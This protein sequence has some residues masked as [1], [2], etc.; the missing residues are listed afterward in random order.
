MKKN[1][2]L[3]IHFPFCEQKCKYC[4]FCSFSGLYDYQEIYIEQLIKEIKDWSS[5]VKNDVLIK[6]IFLG[7][8]TPSYMNDGL[9]KKVL[10]NIYQCFDCSK[11]EEVTI[12]C[13]PN[14]LTL[15][16]LDEYKQAKINRISIGVQ[17][18]DDDVLQ[19]IG[20]VHKAIDVVKAINYVNQYGFNFSVDLM[21]GLPSQ[22]CQSFEETLNKII[23]LRPNHIS[24]YSLILEEGTPLYKMVE[25]NEVC[26]PSEEE[27]L[28]MYDYALNELS[29]NGYSQYEV[30]NFALSNF[31][32]K[33]NI[34]YWQ[35]G[36]Y[37]G[38]GLNAHSYYNGCRFSNTSNFQKYL[39]QNNFTNNA[40]FSEVIDVK[41]QKTEFIMLGLRMNK[42]VDLKEYFKLFKEYLL[43]TKKIVIQN[44]KE[45]GLIDY[46]E[47]Y[48]FVPSNSM[49]VLNQIILELID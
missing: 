7:G 19:S 43:Q 9:I 45:N 21:C 16:K 38:F 25:S 35:C 44:L 27:T 18:L 46:S 37:L 14:S 40:E 39:K 29:K 31:E 17:S 11:L 49:R 13:N 1:I 22:S 34:N 4:D 26:L 36:E 23:K 32:C 41:S 12:E 42:G 15:K 20:R 28:K 10:F 24:C 5:Q 6:T 30:S 8:G 33:H 2:G 47:N 3:Y 48:L